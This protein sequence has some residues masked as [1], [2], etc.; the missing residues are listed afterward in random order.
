MRS[1]KV[2]T[3]GHTRKTTRE[4]LVTQ[5][6]ERSREKVT[7]LDMMKKTAKVLNREFSTLTVMD[8]TDLITTTDH[9]R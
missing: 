7:T 3:L 8:K 2:I 1:K 5:M 4:K 9:S 6:K